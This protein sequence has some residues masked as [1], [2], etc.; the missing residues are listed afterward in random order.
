MCSIS[1]T[2]INVVVQL[3]KGKVS[4]VKE[5]MKLPAMNFGVK[6][7][8]DAFFVVSKDREGFPATLT[9]KP[10]ACNVAPQEE[11]SIPWHFYQNCRINLKETRIDL[12][13]QKF[14]IVIQGTGLRPVFDAASKGTLELIAPCSKDVYFKGGVHDGPL[15]ESV[16]IEE[17]NPFAKPK[18]KG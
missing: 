1:I 15:V 17:V 4:T 14:D 9:V 8:K 11:L 10:G 6:V 12:I 5:V 16:L 7:E 2:V 3:N 13:F 18:A